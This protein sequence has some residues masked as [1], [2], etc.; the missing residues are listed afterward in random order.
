MPLNV[1]GTLKLVTCPRRSWIRDKVM[2]VLLINSL[3]A[4]NHTS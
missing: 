2:E 4:L 1:V 3:F